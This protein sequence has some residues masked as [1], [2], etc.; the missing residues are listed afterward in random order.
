MNFYF[1]NSTD[2]LKKGA[3]GL[4][5][6]DDHCKEVEDL[7]KGLCIVPAITFDKKGYRIGYGMGYYDRFLS[8]FQGRVFGLC[9]S[10]CISKKVPH[11]K[12]DRK[13]S[14][15]ITENRTITCI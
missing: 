15:I 14:A 4:L 12:Y 1:I 10:F 6:P 9:Y 2:D 5:E 13:V 3:F 8:K 7:S 11:G